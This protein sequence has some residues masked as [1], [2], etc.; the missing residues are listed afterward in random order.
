[1]G[2]PDLKKMK[3]FGGN[4]KRFSLLFILVF[5]V[6][7]FGQE[8]MEAPAEEMATDMM[9]DTAAVDTMAMD[10]MLMTD[11]TA[12]E[13]AVMEEEDAGDA[14]EAMLAEEGT[15]ESEVT[16]GSALIGYTAGL[17]IGYPVYMH[18]GL[19]DSY[20]TAGPAF[21]L[22]VNTPFGAAIGPFEIGFGAQI[23]MFSFS[24]STDDRE[25]S[26]VVALA[27]ANTSVFETAQGAITVQIGAGYYGASLGLTAG[28][29]FDYAVPGAPIVLR[30]YARANATLDSGTETSGDDTGSYSWLNIGAMI[31]L[32][33]SALF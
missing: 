23:G 5:A 9:A 18:G 3:N 17:D 12:V 32:D 15:M 30:P 1:M 14:L 33:I 19:G 22:V 26:G 8:A 25:L 11:T 2:Q 10:D 24:N 7:A 20:D 4:M 28:A 27:T 29:A 16:S 13:E 31:S 21:G 6:A